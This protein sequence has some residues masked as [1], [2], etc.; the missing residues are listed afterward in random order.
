MVEITLPDLG[1]GIELATIAQWYVDI[2]DDI[3]KDDD[4]VELVTDKASFELP[5]PCSGRLKEIYFQSGREVPIGSV[6]ATI[7]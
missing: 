3:K 5:S 1:E 2:G 4:I 6:I 7:E